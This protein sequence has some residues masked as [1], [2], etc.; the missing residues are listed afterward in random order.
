LA[1]IGLVLAGVLA[2]VTLADPFSSDPPPRPTPTPRLPSPT[3]TPRLPSP[4]PPPSVPQRSLPSTSGE[5]IRDSF[6]DTTC[7]VMDQE[8]SEPMHYRFG[9]E[10]G[11]YV[12]QIVDPEWAVT[13]SVAPSLGSPSGD[14]LCAQQS[15]AGQY[16]DVVIETEGRLAGDAEGRYLN[17]GCRMDAVEGEWTGYWLTFFPASGFYRLSRQNVGENEELESGTV[18][19]SGDANAAARLVLSCIGDEIVAWINDRTVA[20]ET[21][22]EYEEG[23]LRLGT[24]LGTGEE[25]GTVEARFAYVRVFER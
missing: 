13:E 18:P 8:S 5:I 7:S 3:P 20:V 23:W 1:A 6:D 10:G 17:L 15:G 11:D 25:P 22:S 24:G 9:D 21:D 12:I 16:S 19:T 4:T 2:A 14:V